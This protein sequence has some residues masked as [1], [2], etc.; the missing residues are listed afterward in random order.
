MTLDTYHHGNLKETLISAGLEILSEKG[1]EGLSLRKV[2]KRIGVSH[3]APYKISLRPFRL[4]VM[5]NYIKFYLK[6][7]KNSKMLQPN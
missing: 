5:S 4:L 7:T 3:T 1:I 6:H 2:A